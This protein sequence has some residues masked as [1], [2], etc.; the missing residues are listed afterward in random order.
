MPVDLPSTPADVLELSSRALGLAMKSAVRLAA[1]FGCWKHSYKNAA[2]SFEEMALPDMIYW[3]FK[4]TNP[5]VRPEKGDSIG[6][7][8][9]TDNRDAGLPQGFE[10]QASLTL[11]AAGDLLQADGLDHSKDVLFENIA[12][13]LFDRTISFA[14]F[15]SPI[16]EQELKKEV[17]GDKGPPFECCSRKQFDLLKGHKGKNFTVMNTANNHIF[18]MGVEGIETTQKVLS[19]ENILN[20][21][22]NATPDDFGRGRIIEKE[23][24]RI[25][26]V[27]A[28]FGLNGRV[29]PDGDAYRINVAR[30]L[31]KKAPPELKILKRQIDDCKSKKCDFIVASLHWGHEFEFF[32]RRRQIEIA[33]V[34][35]EYG[36]DA[37]LSHH[38]HVIQPVDYYRT[39]RDPNRIAVIAYSLGTLTWRFTAPQYVLSLILNLTLSKGAYK[40][41][42]VT[43]IEKAAVTPVF[44][45]S[46]DEGGQTV[47]R[48]EKLADY[49]E[50]RKNNHPPE[51]IAKIKEYADLALGQ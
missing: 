16:T 28:T 8:V 38:P 26:F 35:V 22:T 46:V 48:I 19:N 9:K 36:V 5:I 44:R 45:S 14:N 51:Y 31:S 42:E 32:P 6:D 7:I 49:L 10:K 2:T 13:L 20:I 18:D 33:H 21:G 34:L 25:G 1:L 27:S 29:V 50:G 47:T 4:C 15:E 12:D 43:Y 40:G 23:G 30:L 37:I 3:A 17:I 39:H 11:A 24:I 41:K